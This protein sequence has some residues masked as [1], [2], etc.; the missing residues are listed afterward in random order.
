MGRYFRAP[1]CLLGAIFLTAWPLAAH[2]QDTA[3]Q[4]DAALAAL[5]SG[6]AEEA[7][8][9]WT[10]LAK[11]GD[12]AAQ[13]NLAGLYLSGALGE[14]DFDQAL[15]WFHKAAEQDNAS[16]LVSLGHL[17]RT[18]LGNLVPPDREDALAYFRRAEEQGSA[19]GAYF[20]GEMELQD[21]PA[22]ASA[23]VEAIRGAAEAGFPPAMHRVGTFLQSGRFTRKDVPKAATWYEAA[24]DRGLAKSSYRLGKIYL[25]GD[26]LPVDMEAALA[27]FEQAADQGS[28]EAQVDAGFIHMRGLTGSANPAKAVDY[29]SKAAAQW[30]YRAM[31]YLGL[32]RFEGTDTPQD[33]VQAHKWFNLAANGGH[34]EA[35]LMRGATEARLE[36]QQLEQA[37][38]EAQTWFDAN[39]DTPH[40]HETL[41]PHGH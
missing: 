11:H 17:H 32:M 29:F 27:H 5:R 3:G 24:A 18:G 20:A 13:S 21:N 26:G 40:T 9:I 34:A 33:L 14:A 22:D 6:D 30:N 7:R 16:A 36:P 28:V 38:A 41:E 12:P 15:V 23:A 39:H 25:Y 4:S 2:A 8:E 35:H 31:Y 37:R 10:R 19:E 1:I